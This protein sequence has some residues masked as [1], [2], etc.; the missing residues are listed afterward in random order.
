MNRRELV[1]CVGMHRSGTSLTAS[2]LK[3]LGI[4][5][6]GELIA[7]D[8]ANL[9]GYFENRTIVAA[10]E[11]LLQDLG[12]WWP[13][14]RASRGMPNSVVKRKVYTDYIDCVVQRIN[15][16]GKFKCGTI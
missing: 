4:C 8:S 9:S 6:P 7:A 15:R 2:M 10:Q 16:N 12:Y 11:K 13:T 5:L 14:E 3:S 1:L